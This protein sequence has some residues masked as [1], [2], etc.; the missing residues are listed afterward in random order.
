MIYLHHHI[1]NF[2]GFV[3][4]VCSCLFPDVLDIFIIVVVVHLVGIKVS[5]F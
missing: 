2:G 1:V 3:T 5:V 4:K